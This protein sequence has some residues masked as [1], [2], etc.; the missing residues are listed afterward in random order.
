MATGKGRFRRE[1]SRLKEASV[2]H[3]WLLD[4][5]AACKWLEPANPSYPFQHGPP[6]TAPPSLGSLDG[7]RALE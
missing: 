4:L 7:G 6:G 2:L 5:E 3:H 1:I